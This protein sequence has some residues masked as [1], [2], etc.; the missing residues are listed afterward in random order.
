MK[1]PKIFSRHVI[2][3]F[4]S[5]ESAQR[6]SLLLKEDGVLNYIARPSDWEIWVSKSTKL[7]HGLKFKTIRENY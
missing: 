5:F 2:G 7:P 1:S 4:A 3:P 6:I